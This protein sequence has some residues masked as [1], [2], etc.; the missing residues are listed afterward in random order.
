[1]LAL[2]YHPLASFCHKVLIA[3]YEHGTAF[4]PRIVDLS[5]AA[6]SEPFFKLWPVGKIPVL[7]D[8]ARDRTLPETTII[9]EYLERHHPGSV[10]LLPRDGDEALEAR[11]WDRFFDHYVNVPMQKIVTDELRPDGGRDPI[12]VAQA[13][14]TLRTAYAML[15]ERMAAPAR[16]WACG[17]TFGLADCAAAP[18]LWYADTVE[19]MRPSHPRAAAYLARLVA[20]PSFARVL[21]EARPYMHNY[22]YRHALPPEFRPAT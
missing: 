12:G 11:L 14:E 7:R 17:E 20:R 4:D 8:E 10:S 6:A 21:E 13:R 15:D 1:M 19:P 5:D 2:Y 22:P 18:A 3:L 16:T 9:I